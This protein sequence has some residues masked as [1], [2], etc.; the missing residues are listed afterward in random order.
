MLVVL[1]EF[2]VRRGYLQ[3]IQL[4]VLIVESLNYNLEGFFVLGTHVE[5]S[6]FVFV[7]RGFLGEDGGLGPGDGRSE[8]IHE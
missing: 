6:L 5:L 1:K 3:L 2:F 4:L 8:L 7:L